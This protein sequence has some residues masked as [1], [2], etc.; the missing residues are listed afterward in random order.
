MALHFSSRFRGSFFAWVGIVASS[1]VIYLLLRP[2][3]GS[4]ADS[5]RKI[6]SVATDVKRLQGQPIAAW[7]IAI[8]RGC[9]LVPLLRSGCAKLFGETVN[10]DL[11]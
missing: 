10:A 11:R 4:L 1:I 8:A 5:A 7:M 9:A 2:I 3:A 6:L